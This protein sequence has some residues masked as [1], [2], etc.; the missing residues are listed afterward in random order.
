MVGIEIIALWVHKLNTLS[1]V[2]DLLAAQNNFSR[3]SSH[4]LRS[5]CFSPLKLALDSKKSKLV[6]L[7][8]TGLNV[9]IYVVNFFLND[10]PL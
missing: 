1:F 5:V 2:A 8:L 7:A 3:N 6:S 10:L 4:E 9:S